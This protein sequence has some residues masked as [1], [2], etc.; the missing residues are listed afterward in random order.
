[1]DGLSGKI[2]KQEER[3]KVLYVD[4]LAEVDDK[5]GGITESIAIME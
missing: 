2:S 5:E 3:R 4:D 1:M